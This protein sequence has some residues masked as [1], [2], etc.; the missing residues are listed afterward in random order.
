MIVVKNRNNKHHQGCNWCKSEE[1]DKFLSAELAVSGSSPSSAA[2]VLFTA[3]SVLSL[4]RLL[5]GPSGQ[6]K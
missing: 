2:C 3:A 1:E 5:L 6:V 4:L